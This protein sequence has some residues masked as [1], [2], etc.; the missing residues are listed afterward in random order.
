[1]NLRTWIVGLC[2]TG[3]CGLSAN[4]QE[5]RFDAGLAL[6]LTSNQ[7]LKNELTRN[8][9][10]YGVEAGFHGQLAATEVPFRVGLAYNAFPGK[11]EGGVKLSLT[12]LQLNGDLFI[13]SG[14]EPLKFVAGLSINTWKVKIEAPG[15]SMSN[16]VDG[17]KVGG[18]IGFDY[19][20][21]DHW[22][23]NLLW[24]V[25]ELG[26]DQDLIENGDPSIAVKAVN[27][28]W[29]QLGVRYRF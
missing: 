8:S 29:I 1:M 3:V 19:K 26:T 16:S 20:I 28:S 14:W 17:L 24:Q 6:N 12:N 4:A 11:D 21:A 2:L 27:P 22:H 5:S 9:L 7:S 13:N 25:S 18:R 23:A 10:G 15:V